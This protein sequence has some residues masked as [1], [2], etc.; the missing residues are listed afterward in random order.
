MIVDQYEDQIIQ[1][2]V[3]GL[4]PATICADIGLCPGGSCGVCTLALQFLYEILPTNQSEVRFYF[5]NE[6]ILKTLIRLVL[7][8]LCNLLPSPNGEVLIFFFAEDVTHA[9]HH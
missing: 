1:G 8:E 5:T 7:D 2:I 9:E 3:N 4:P 6:L